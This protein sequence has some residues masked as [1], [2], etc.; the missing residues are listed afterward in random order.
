LSLIALLHRLDLEYHTDSGLPWW[1]ARPPVE[2]GAVTDGVALVRE[3]EEALSDRVIEALDGGEAAV[4]E[5]FVD[6]PPKMFGGL[7]LGTMGGLEYKTNAVMHG[8]IW[9]CPGF[10]ER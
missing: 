9:T 2:K 3:S 10:V 6:E 1:L 4:G 8:E 7:E 5:R